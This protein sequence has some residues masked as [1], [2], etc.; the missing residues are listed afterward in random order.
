MMPLPASAGPRALHETGA[1]IRRALSEDIEA[2]C[3]PA[4]GL[5]AASVSAGRWPEAAY[6]AY[7]TPDTGSGGLQTRALFVACVRAGA[8]GFPM[9]TA[10][11]MEEGLIGV[12]AFSAIPG[13]G[14]CALDNMV[15]TEAWR[16]QGI[17]TRLLGAGLLWCRAHSGSSV[18]LE[19]RASNMGAIQMYER[20]G[21]SIAGRRPDYYSDPVEG[22]I[23]MQKVVG[24]GARESSNISC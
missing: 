7:V 5:A 4:Y 24:K 13:V 22:A 15:V 23:E 10:P 21:F 2:I 9:R 12:A 18:W 11:I 6:R 1:V 20:A 19:V 16:R 14:E 8:S 17:G 3:N